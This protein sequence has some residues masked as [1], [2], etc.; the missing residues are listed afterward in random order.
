MYL[1]WKVTTSLYVHNVHSGMIQKKCLLDGSKQL[2]VCWNHF[3]VIARHHHLQPLCTFLTGLHFVRPIHSDSCNLICKKLAGECTS[4]K[5]CDQ[6]IPRRCW[7]ACCCIKQT[8]LCTILICTVVLKWCGCRLVCC[9]WILSELSGRT[10]IYLFC[11]SLYRFTLRAESC[12][13]N[14]M[15]QKTSHG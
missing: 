13:S 9:C 6:I 3:T 8:C 11:S 10:L 12:N 2:D 15:P 4:R 14:L 1:L 7:V 5:D